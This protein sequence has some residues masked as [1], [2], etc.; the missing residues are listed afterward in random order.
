MSESLMI[1]QIALKNEQ[2]DK[3]IFFCQKSD[4]L[5]FTSSFDL[6]LKKSEQFAQNN[7][8]R[9]SNPAKDERIPNLAKDQGLLKSLEAGGEAAVARP[10]PHRGG[11]DTTYW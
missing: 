3:N 6:L 1:E 8:E 11:G 10:G 2:F 9:I 7:D 5:F 4:L